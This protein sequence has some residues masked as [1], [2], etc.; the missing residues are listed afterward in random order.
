MTRITASSRR[1]PCPVC[2]RTKDGDCRILETGAVFCHSVPEEKIGAELNGYRYAKRNDDG[3]TG[4]WVP[5]DQWR[6]GRKAAPTFYDTAKIWWYQDQQGR[7]A[8][9][10]KAEGFERKQVSAIAGKKVSEI[11]KNLVPYRYA[12]LIDIKKVY[13]VE[14]EKCADALWDL[15][16]PATTFNG[17]C[18]GFKPE[19]DAGNFGPDVTLILCPDRDQP[20]VAYMQQIAD[21]YSNNVK[22]WLRVWPEEPEFWGEKCPTVGG[23]DVADWLAGKDPE[24]AQQMIATAISEDP[25]RLASAGDSN[26][27]ILKT[28]AAHQN[29]KEFALQI[30]TRDSELR[31]TL[32]YE[33]AKKLG[34]SLSKSQCQKYLKA[35]DRHFRGVRPSFQISPRSLKSSPQRYLLEGIIPLHQ[36]TLLVAREKLGKTTLMLQLVLVQSEGI[37][38]F[39]GKQLIQTRLK[40]YIVGTDQPEHNWEE[41]M[42]RV[43]LN[44]SNIGS[45]GN[46]VRYLATMEEEIVLTP[47]A[48]T[49]LR[50]M[51]RGDL[52]DG[53]EALL[54]IDSFDACIRAIGYEERDAAI[55]DPLRQLVSAFEGMP[56]TQVILHHETKDAPPGVDAF[57]AL[58]G[59]S[60]IGSTVSGGIRLEAVDPQRK[61]SAISLKVKN[62]SCA[63]HEL[64]LERSND[65]SFYCVG[66]GTD[67]LLAQAMRTQQDALQENQ[68][69]AL[70]FIRQATIHG[71][72][73]TVAELAETDLISSDLFGRARTD[74]AR[75]IIQSLEDRLL[76]RQAQ[77]KSLSGR[78]PNAWFAVKITGVWSPVNE[79]P[80]SISTMSTISLSSDT[81]VSD[82]V[83]ISDTSG[84]CSETACDNDQQMTLKT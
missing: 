12:E 80:N 41:I 28:E 45:E 51:I 66:D 75:Q 70:D 47:D 11:N 26:D 54:M 19:R 34:T 50:D 65:G 42:K 38:T 48:I 3:R 32:M 58:R 23:L 16:I 15:G 25:I 57:R 56:V 83:D 35:A 78:P 29:L 27:G 22:F 53:E 10:F 73:V 5:V 18:K 43:G 68:K 36:Q 59:H 40:I 67:V 33:K 6:E 64:L 44:P 84:G 30:Q 8:V 79:D 21:A 14:G 31:P 17:G 71:K 81:S 72:S 62:R 37:E 69:I 7:N 4:T 1:N 60:S 52:D 76:V 49:K 61:D 13:I 9:G 46:P 63:A 82:N 55:S 74:R 24:T 77:T 20:G 39:L 2:G